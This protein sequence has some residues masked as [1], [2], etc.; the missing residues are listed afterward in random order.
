MTGDDMVETESG[1]TRQRGS[2]DG[3]HGIYISYGETCRLGLSAAVCMWSGP[4]QSSQRGAILGRAQ[5]AVSARLWSVMAG[6]IEA[7][8]SN[9]PTRM[10]PFSF[11]PYVLL[12]SQADFHSNW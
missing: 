6:L 2:H 1:F 3:S 12:I 10:F 11:S 9:V 7:G 8:S 4:R 5:L